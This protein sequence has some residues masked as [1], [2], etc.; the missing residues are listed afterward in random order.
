[1]KENIIRSSSQHG[2]TTEK[3]C[4]TTLISFYNEITNLM[5]ER[6]IIYLDFSKTFDTFYTVPHEILTDK[7]LK[8]GLYEH[9]SEVD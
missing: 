3:S 1:M 8:Y 7:L 5:D 2:F 6:E 4:L 9:T